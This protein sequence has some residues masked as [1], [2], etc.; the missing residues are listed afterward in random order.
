MSSRFVVLF[1]AFIGLLVVSLVF[2]E[3]I[4]LLDSS[5][6]L[7]LCFDV[8]GGYVNRLYLGESNF[9]MELR[10]YIATFSV[11]SLGTLAFFG[12]FFNIK[13]GGVV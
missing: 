13:K 4:H 7:D 6:P 3:V 11:L 5:V 8:S 1:F 10:A 2:H 9:V 12:W